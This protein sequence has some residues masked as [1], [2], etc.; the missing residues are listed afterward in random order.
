MA[1][2]IRNPKSQMTQ[3]GMHVRGSHREKFRAICSFVW[4][5]VLY[6][7]LVAAGFWWW[8]M[9]GGFPLVHPRFW[10]NAVLPVAAGAVC[11]TCLLSERRKNAAWRMATGAALP[12]FWLA[13]CITAALLFP[14]S[15]RRFGVPA[16]GC[17][18]LIATAFWATTRG[19]RLPRRKVVISTISAGIVAAGFV[20]AQRAPRAGTRPLGEALPSIHEDVEPARAGLPV[21]LSQGVTI[22]PG[23]GQ[24]NFV[25]PLQEGPSRKT[26]SNQDSGA[27]PERSKRYSLE[28]Q[29]LLTF[30]S[31]SPDRCWT[32]FARRRDREGP[33]RRLISLHRSN[34]ELL[35]HFRDDGESALKIS[36]TETRKAVVIEGWTRLNRPIY[37]HLNSYATITVLGCQRPA[38]AFSPCPAVLV[39]VEPFD[40]PVGRPMRLGY[41]DALNRFHVVRARS[42]EKGPFTEFGSGDLAR[43]DALTMT[44]FDGKSPVCR[45]SLDDWSAQASHDLSPTAGWGLP[46]NAIEFSQVSDAS[47]GSSPIVIGITLSGTSVGRGWDSVG[48]AAGTYRNRMRIEWME[49][50]AE[51]GIRNSE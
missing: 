26:E 20:W 6:A 1:K 14:M 34:S 21:T 12:A 46:A 29:P 5:V 10:T 33:E 25:Q 28:I 35:A 24:I 42:G 22:F 51:F 30:E 50:S 39:D 15:A 7:H 23:V 45:I 40:Y 43:D 9:P 47:L 2:E 48:H 13:A 38:L 19:E 4:R 41:V 16:A 18:V 3:E 17:T 27:T 49:K 37:S 36:T 32:I 31:R 8:L 44:V 11:F